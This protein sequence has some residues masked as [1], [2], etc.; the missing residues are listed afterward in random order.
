M[1]EFITI[2]ENLSYYIAN[3]LNEEG[4]IIASVIVQEESEEWIKN[5][6]VNPESNLNKELDEL[7]KGVESD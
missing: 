4:L 3:K 1:I 5:Q 7:V 6:L 2:D